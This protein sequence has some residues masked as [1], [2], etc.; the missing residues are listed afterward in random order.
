VNLTTWSKDRPA[1][2]IDLTRPGALASLLD[3][4]GG[5]RP[6]VLAAVLGLAYSIGAQSAVLEYRYVDPDYRNENSR[7]YST[8]FRRYPSVAHRLHFFGDQI[9]TA[10][11]SDDEIARF[12]NLGYL[13]YVVLRPLPGAPV[14]RTMLAP[15]HGTKPHVTCLTTDRVNLLGES[16]KVVAAPF[17]SQDAQMS[18]CAHATLWMIAYYHHLAFG[19]PRLLPGDIAAAV[20]DDV[21]RGTPS[22]GL[23]LYQIS[24]AA[25]RLGYP[26]LVYGLDP[27]PQDESV[28][29]LAC[30]YLNS[31]IPVIVGGAGHVFVLLGYE[32]LKPGQA[33]ERI[34]FIR[35]DDE[36]GVYLDVD[37]YLLD[38]Y[39]PWDY[40]VIPLPQKVYMP[41]EDAE[42]IGA[43]FLGQALD[44][45]LDPA[46]R[47]LRERLGDPTR[48]LS[49]RS[50]VLRSNEF[51]ERLHERQVP[52]PLAAVYRRMQMSRW[53]WVV[54]LIDRQLR[55]LNK[56]C[57]LAEAI[58]DATDQLRDSHALAWRIP[59][60]VS[61]WS[62]DDDSISK[63]PLDA[64]PPLVSVALAQG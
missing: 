1:D 7:F 35:H 10:L 14:G 50:T 61:Q 13:G 37:N 45:S 19:G 59:G 49:F 18:V 58:I 57:V 20:P 38:D 26:A 42:K 47:Q 43:A 12:N 24:V 17:V 36:T 54:E 2:A 46:A 3:T 11:I 34:R 31:G 5:A 16:L 9:P 52:E 27:P 28:F 51:K 21:G 33:D 30:R 29:R 44:D 55:A 15:P 41:G 40:L 60:L 64:T 53:V 8:T 32:R 63:R 39:A 56:P 23:T 48:P 25:S 62:P 6:D 4:Y 22:M